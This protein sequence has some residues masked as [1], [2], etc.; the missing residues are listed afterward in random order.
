MRRF[1]NVTSSHPRPAIS[2]AAK[3]PPPVSSHLPFTP[4][5]SRTA[6]L[7]LPTQV[8]GLGSWDT[9]RPWVLGLGHGQALGS[10]VLGL[11]SWV[12]GLGSWVLGL[13]SWV[14]FGCLWRSKVR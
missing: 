11:G 3:P 9:P 5:R 2:S 13:G 1:A 8:L 12:L 10:W 4:P 14:L 7:R 6:F